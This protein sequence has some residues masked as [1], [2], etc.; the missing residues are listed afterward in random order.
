MQL[1]IAPEG[2]IYEA[3]TIGRLD[4]VTEIL[5]RAPEKLNSV[6]PGRQNAV[7]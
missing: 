2:A 4:I 7:A 1:A 3:V 5:A 6:G